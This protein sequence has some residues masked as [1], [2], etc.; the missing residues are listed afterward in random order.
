MK[1]TRRFCDGER[2]HPYLGR[3]L[4]S[5]AGPLR[6]KYP[7]LKF[8]NDDYSRA[9]IPLLDQAR[10]IIKFDARN[11]LPDW[12]P[13]ELTKLVKRQ[14]DIPIWIPNIRL[15]W[16]DDFESEPVRDFL[17]NSFENIRLRLKEG[18]G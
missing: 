6:D 7:E 1:D 17:Q 3:M 8:L 10:L 12:L 9:A 14:P 11:K 13:D 5:G 18:L 4:A 2:L 16:L 15:D